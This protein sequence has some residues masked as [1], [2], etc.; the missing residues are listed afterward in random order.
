MTG[1]EV[2]AEF[3]KQLLIFFDELIGQFPEEADLIIARLFIANQL[4][5]ED[6]VNRFLYNLN[7]DDQFI[8]KMIKERNEVFF[9]EKEVFPLGES[10][11]DP[12]FFKRLWKSNVLDSG[13]KEI[14]WKWMDTFV[15][16]G[17]K[18]ARTKQQ[19]VEST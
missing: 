14:I 16:L 19:M 13:D 7:Y 17:D 15:L 9:L 2:L 6:A 5:M 1:V 11:W 12:N 4:P 8:R 18:F 10:K 3:N